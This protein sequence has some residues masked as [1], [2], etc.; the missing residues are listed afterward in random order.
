MK[1]NG[2]VVVEVSNLKNRENGN[3]TTLAWDVGK[4]ISQVMHFVG[5]IIVCWEKKNIPSEDGGAY[6]YGYDHSYAL[7][8]QNKKR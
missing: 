8:F 2:Y 4:T 1:L 7:V 3:V 5:E 6:G